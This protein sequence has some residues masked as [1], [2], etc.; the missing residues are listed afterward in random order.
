[1]VSSEFKLIK[2]SLK[3]V[4]ETTSA[5]LLQYYSLS[6]CSIKTVI[7]LSTS[8]GIVASTTEGKKTSLEA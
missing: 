5:L 8:K 3:D 7:Y 4:Q 1:M 6:D 2:I